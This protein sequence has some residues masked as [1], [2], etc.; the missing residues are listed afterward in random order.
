LYYFLFQS[1]R[2][3]KPPFP[4]K[5]AVTTYF[6]SVYFTNSSFNFKK[7]ASHGEPEAA[8]GNCT[9]VCTLKHKIETI[10]TAGDEGV[11]ASARQPA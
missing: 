7:F 2:N 6:C 1:F 4:A 10:P 8:P 9:S 5:S 11:H 3:K